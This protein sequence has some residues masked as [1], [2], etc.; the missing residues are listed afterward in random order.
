MNKAFFKKHFLG[1]PVLLR[2]WNEAGA[3]Q[4][5]LY[6][7]LFDWLYEKTRF[8][9]YLLKSAPS[10]LMFGVYGQERAIYRLGWA[11]IEGDA[12]RVRLR[13]RLYK[14]IVTNAEMKSAGGVA[15]RNE[16]NPSYDYLLTDENFEAVVGLISH[17][18][19]S[20]QDSLAD[21]AE[22][23][24]PATAFDAADLVADQSGRRSVILYGD[25]VE[26]IAKA[27]IGQ[28]GFRQALLKRW[29]GC[30]VT[31]VNDE[32]LLV[33]SHIE[34]WALSGPE[35]KVDVDNGLLLS[36]ALD[37]AFDAYLISF[38]AL[39]K[40]VIDP[41]AAG[42]LAALGIKPSMCIRELLNAKQ[43]AYLAKH[44]EKFEQ[45]MSQR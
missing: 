42:A 22:R 23:V 29:G 9:V 1:N 36:P 5:A 4:Q 44:L 12:V 15:V 41:S 33:A 17:C 43:A 37:Y 14:D 10:R 39:G 18:L 19:P 27:R 40:I 45:K 7:R 31:G 24:L 11:S 28:S 25:E 38:D 6:L 2:Q 32:R 20:F 13:N 8:D 26:V 35:E 21:G 16:P 34:P 30:A 3:G